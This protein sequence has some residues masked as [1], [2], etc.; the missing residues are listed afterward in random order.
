LGGNNNNKHKT[1]APP[2]VKSEAH[3]SLTQGAHGVKR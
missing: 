3:L 2:R 1:T